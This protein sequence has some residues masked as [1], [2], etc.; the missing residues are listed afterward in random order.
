MSQGVTFVTGKGGVGKSTV[1]AALARASGARLAV[2]AHTGPSGALVLRPAECRQAV[3]ARLFGSR[4]LARA[5]LGSE[6]V[7]AL[8]DVSDAV[9]ALVAFAELERAAEGAPLVFDMPATGHALSWFRSLPVLE[10]LAGGGRLKA[11]VASVRRWIRAPQHRLAIVTTAESFVL[12]ETRELIEAA[13]SLPDAL[14]DQALIVN[15]VPPARSAPAS[16]SSFPEA[17]AR[18]NDW[19]M[20]RTQAEAFRDEAGAST[21][22]LV[23]RIGARNLVAAMAEELAA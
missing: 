3:A 5:F 22:L 16:A 7:R 18:L 6:P 11:F 21:H 2:F 10:G 8:L 4:R 17:H 12:S 20:L 13:R 1:A 23:D 9:T 19:N 14:A 15:R